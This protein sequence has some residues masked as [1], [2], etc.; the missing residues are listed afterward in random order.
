MMLLRLNIQS[1]LSR[2]APVSITV[3]AIALSVAMLLFV[4][5]LRVGARDGFRQTI[6]QTDLIVG[7]KGG[8]LQLLMYTVFRLGDATANIDYLS[9]KDIASWPEVKWTIPY[10]LG[11]SYRGFR[12]VGTTQDFFEHYR[13]Y[14]SQQIRFREGAFSG[15]VFDV[16]LGAEV[17]QRTEIAVGD[18]IVL[19]HGVGEISFQDH[20][21]S[22]FK[23]VGILEPTHT[24]IDKSLYISLLGMEAIHMGWEDGSAEFIDWSAVNW[25]EVRVKQI[26]SFLIGLESRLDVLHMQRKILNYEEEP[27]MA[28]IPG[29]VLAM[30]WEGLGYVEMGLRVATLALVFVGLLGMIVAIYYALYL[31]SREIAI[32]RAVGV[33]PWFV[34]GLLVTEGALVSGVGSMLG[35]FLLEVFVFLFS[36]SLQQL[37]GVNLMARTPMEIYLLILVVVCGSFMA[38][39]PAVKAYMQSLHQGLS[40]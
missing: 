17:A 5:R 30:L 8:P 10:S 13:Y 3:L 24:P 35:V 39:I 12:V 19:S 26:T 32:L 33:S 14:G 21:D 9:Y 31:R 23:V 29:E 11:D 28:I 16:V 2:F 20:E 40:G 37:A 7:A 25:D 36:S 15:G 34:F 6:S 1:L 18:E 4:E 38:V 22:P 27:L